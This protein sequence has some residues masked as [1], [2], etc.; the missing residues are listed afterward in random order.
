MP[1]STLVFV[2]ALARPTSTS[3]DARLAPSQRA[4][5]FTGP[6]LDRVEVPLAVLADVGLVYPDAVD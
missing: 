5:D 3:T 2:L 6:R 1:V 4:A